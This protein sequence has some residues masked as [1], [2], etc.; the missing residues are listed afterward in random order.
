MK[1]LG[2]NPF[3]DDG[4]AARSGGGGGGGFNV[5]DEIKDK[6]RTI[7]ERIQK[8]LRDR[9]LE[10]VSGGHRKVSVCWCLRES[11]IAEVNRLC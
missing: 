10:V 4:Q 11:C 6:L 9:V 2:G 8:G 1:V 3:S 7:I 5:F